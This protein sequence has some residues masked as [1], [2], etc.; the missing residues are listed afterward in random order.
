MQG[1]YFLITL[2]RIYS[3]APKIFSCFISMLSVQIIERA[4]NRY[5][6]TWQNYV[7][8]CNRQITKSTKKQYWF[9][10]QPYYPSS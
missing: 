3:E 9:N 7:F 4:T 6:K 2:L 8:S 5:A 10:K 1:D